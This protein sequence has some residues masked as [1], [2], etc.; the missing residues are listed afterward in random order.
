MSI[1][2]YLREIG[3]GKEGARA[4]TRAQAADLMRQ[5]LAGQ[6]SDV[7]TGGFALAMR[8]KGETPEE[9]AGFMDAA[10]PLCLALAAPS[11]A[12]VLPSY[13]GARKLPNFTPLLALLLA[14]AGVPVLVHGPLRDAGRVASAEIFEA[15]GLPPVDSAAAVQ[16]RWAAGAPAFLAIDVLHPA[17]TRLLALRR[18]LGL[19]NPAHT[20]AKLL[21]AV[22]GAVRVVNHTHPEYAVS[23]S[24]FLALNQADA[25]LLRG[26]EGEPVADARRVPKME[27]FVD[28][29]PQPALSVALEEGSLARLPELPAIDAAST[30]RHAEAVLAG[31]ATVPAS[32]ARQVQCL[33]ALRRAVAARMLP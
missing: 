24:A 27:A 26:T 21:P 3:R 17:L 20:L 25:L 30:A 8:I 32:M 4:L 16:A 28:G 7:E 6:V 9:L 5:L 14:R 19:R 13:N 15:L 23:L 1:A 11:T 12:V 33:L 29:V 31:D 10:Q 22:P 18:V 2:P